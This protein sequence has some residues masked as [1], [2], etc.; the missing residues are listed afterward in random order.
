MQNCCQV[1]NENLSFNDWFSLRNLDAGMYGVM[2]TGP[3]SL[4]PSQ[5]ENPSE[6]MVRP[7]IITLNVGQIIFRWGDSRKRNEE[8]QG[9]PW[10]STPM[11]A[12]QIA[13][14]AGGAA[15]T[16]DAARTFSKVARS[17]NNPLDTL[18][19]ARV[20]KPVKCFMGMGRDIWDEAN[21]E[22]MGHRGVQLY[23]PGLSVFTGGMVHLS[24]P[25]KAHLGF[26]RPRP[27]ST[28]NLEAF[29]DIIGR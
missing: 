29:L 25:A 26:H 6:T 2:R 4:D 8:N 14:M 16:S 12:G 15:S 24:N 11:S 22:F 3:N 5:P 13:T 10:W 20:A 28:L 9:S 21:R 7:R 17:W 27:A 23:I 1:L 19:C 18:V